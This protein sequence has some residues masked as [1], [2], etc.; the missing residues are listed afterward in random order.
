MSVLAEHAGHSLPACARSALRCPIGNYKRVR[1]PARVA[2]SV[3]RH[4][5]S[6]RQRRRRTGLGRREGKRRRETETGD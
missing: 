5:R 6:R 1:A 2:A 3:Q 4:S